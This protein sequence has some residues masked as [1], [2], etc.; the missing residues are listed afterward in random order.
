MSKDQLKR[1]IKD[2]NLDPELQ[3]LIYELVDGA[4]EVNKELLS[5]VADAIDLQADFYGK[6]AEIMEEEAD[7]ME[8]LSAELELLDTEE[9]KERLEAMKETQDGLLSDLNEKMESTKNTPNHTPVPDQ[10]IEEL[11]NTL[12]QAAQP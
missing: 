7:A 9:I 11:K 2:L 6:T 1:T 8:S 4:S 12:S 5:A 10:K 3:K